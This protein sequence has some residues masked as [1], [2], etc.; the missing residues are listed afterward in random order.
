MKISKL[1]KEGKIDQKMWSRKEN[2]NKNNSKIEQNS[3]KQ[4]SFRVHLHTN[5]EKAVQL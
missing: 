3:W 2:F 1:R 5:T 4:R